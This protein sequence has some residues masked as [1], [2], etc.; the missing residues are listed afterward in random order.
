[1]YLRLKL[2]ELA[3]KRQAPSAYQS[4]I[5]AMNS[6]L[7]QLMRP[8]EIFSQLDA[9]QIGIVPGEYAARYRHP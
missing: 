5:L 4:Q 7:T 8:F 6:F 1:V 3:A 2:T 9:P